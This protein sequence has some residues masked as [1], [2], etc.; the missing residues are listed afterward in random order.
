MTAF[1]KLK[2]AHFDKENSLTTTSLAQLVSEAIG[3]LFIGFIISAALYGVMCAQ[4]CLYFKRHAQDS[5][6]LKSIVTILI[7]LETLNIILATHGIFVCAVSEPGTFRCFRH[8]PRTIVV[9]ILP[10]ALIVALVQYVWVMRIKTLSH[11]K[12]KNQLVV[13]MLLLIFTGMGM[14]ISTYNTSHTCLSNG[15]K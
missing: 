13:C 4:A 8:P 1:P 7:L 12:R 3:P 2:R 10:T 11:S 15:L 9:Q 14:S 6:R 5:T